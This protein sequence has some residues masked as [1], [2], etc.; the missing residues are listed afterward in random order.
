VR[1]LLVAVDDLEA[2]QRPFV[3][4]GCL[5]TLSPGTWRWLQRRSAATGPDDPADVASS[6]ST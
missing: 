6:A 2:A 5:S 1:A 4:W 3:T